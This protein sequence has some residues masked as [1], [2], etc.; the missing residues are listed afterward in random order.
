MRAPSRR[1]KSSNCSTGSSTVQ[2]DDGKGR[3]RPN[4]NVPFGVHR[5]LVD[6]SPVQLLYRPGGK[7]KPRYRALSDD[8][9]RA[10]LANVDA[11]MRFQTGGTGRT[12]RLAHALRLL[13]L[14]GQ[15][16]G[17]LA[18]ARW[19]DVTLS[20]K[21]PVWRIPSEQSKTSAA[22]VAPLASLAVAEFQALKK[23]A[24]GSACISRPFS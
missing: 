2:P 6:A 10:F 12:P 14:T 20:G 16:C 18:L 23:H 4:S 9:L 19:Q 13:S 24:D 21:A 11:V 15:R 22:H 5:A 17:E 3:G 1:A 7:E 8:E